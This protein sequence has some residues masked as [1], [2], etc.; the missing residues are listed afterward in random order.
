LK[1]DVSRLPTED[2]VLAVLY[3]FDGYFDPP[4]SQ[5]VSFSLREFAEKLFGLGE[6]YAAKDGNVIGFVG[7]YCNDQVRGTAYVSVLAVST[8]YQNR[9]V[10]KA[11]LERCVAVARS[12]GMESIKLEVRKYA[13]DAIRFYERNDFKYLAEASEASFYMAKDLGASR[14]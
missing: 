3:Q 13:F 9:H 11:L 10:G 6:I 12:V 4:L 8:H 7:F 1:W 5:R 14:A 2:E